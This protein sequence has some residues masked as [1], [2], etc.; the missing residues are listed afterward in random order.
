MRFFL[1]VL[2][3][4]S[5]NG[6]SQCKSFIIGVNG[7]TLNCV[8]MKGKKQGRW[9]IQVPE[10]RGERGYEEEGVFLNNL[11]EGPWRRYSLQ[12][13]LIAYEN[14]RWGNKD[15]KNIYYDF[16]GNLVREESWK[17]V[18]P[19]NPYDTVDVYDPN[20]PSLVIDHV[21]VKLEGFSL[22][23]GTW[24]FYDPFGGTLEKTE[25]WWLDKPA[26]SSGT[27]VAANDELA[28][29]DVRDSKSD[30]IGKKAVT[31]PQAILDYEKK[32]S[33]KK[34]IRVRDGRTGG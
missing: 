34:K 25:K 23:H 13:D 28:P 26:N 33:G 6:F 31:K 1:V 19:D 24:K 20:D 4:I 7:D 17:A 10:L 14:Y 12:G 11:K 29:I 21:V 8:D 2:M 9:V 16:M 3:L 5:I 22:K 18:N 30:T 32:N 15:G 27:G